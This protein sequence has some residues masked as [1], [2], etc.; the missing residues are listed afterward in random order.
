MRRPWVAVFVGLLGLIAELAVGLAQTVP[1]S[2][3]NTPEPGLWI[4]ISAIVQ[5][6]LPKS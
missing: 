1:A 5:R 3:M 2:R 6:R 4:S